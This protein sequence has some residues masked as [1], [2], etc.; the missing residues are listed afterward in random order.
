MSQVQ[1]ARAIWLRFVGRR[2]RRKSICKMKYKG[3][4]EARWTFGEPEDARGMHETSMD[5]S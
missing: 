1:E 2:V 4:E 5:G 3:G